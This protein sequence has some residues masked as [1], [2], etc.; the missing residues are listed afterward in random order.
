[1]PSRS[2]GDQSFIRPP[3]IVDDSG[4]ILVFAS[5][6]EAESYL[7]PWAA[8]QGIAVYDAEGRLVRLVRRGPRVRVAPGD[9]IPWHSE[10]LR[11]RLVSYLS[12]IGEERTKRSNQWLIDAPL[13]ELIEL[14]A[15]WG[16]LG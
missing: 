8:K 6:E 4:D 11:D 12:R 10:V 13:S 9:S 2:E 1:M 15:D 16:R 7:E 5:V 14:A 3:L